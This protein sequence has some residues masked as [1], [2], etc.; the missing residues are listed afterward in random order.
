MALAKAPLHQ[1][2]FARPQ[3]HLTGFLRTAAGAPKVRISVA[4]RGQTYSSN[5]GKKKSNLNLFLHPV[6]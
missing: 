5:F 4:C 1:A 6:P 2:R 3:R